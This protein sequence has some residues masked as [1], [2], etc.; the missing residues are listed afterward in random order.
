MKLTAKQLRLINEISAADMAKVL[1]I[2]TL[3]YTQKEV[4]KTRFYVDEAYRIADYF[5]KD[6][7]DIQWN[8]NISINDLL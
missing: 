6:I 3:T 8:R 2:G 4:G 7:D 1:G 5:K